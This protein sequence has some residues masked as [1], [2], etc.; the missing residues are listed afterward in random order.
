MRMN[1][2]NQRI[3]FNIYSKNTISLRSRVQ[4]FINKF[5][6]FIYIVTFIYYYVIILQRVLDKSLLYKLNFINYIFLK[7]KR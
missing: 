7:Y 6:I 1:L 2:V 3:S 5:I 4:L